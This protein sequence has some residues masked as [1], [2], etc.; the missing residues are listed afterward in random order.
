MDSFNGE[1]WRITH[2]NTQNRTVEVNITQ[3][4]LGNVVLGNAIVSW[5]L[6]FSISCSLRVAV[7]VF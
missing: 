6:R 4:Y 7:A 5:F 3:R 2:R 1:T